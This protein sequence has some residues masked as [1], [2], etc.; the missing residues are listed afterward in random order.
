[1]FDRFPDEPRSPK[2]D[3]K[4]RCTGCDRVVSGDDVRCPHCGTP[5]HMR[6]AVYNMRKAI[7]ERREK[8]IAANEQLRV[9]R[10]TPKGQK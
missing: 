3:G 10:L 2:P 7:R 5:N 4:N 8:R 9:S 1:M 6:T